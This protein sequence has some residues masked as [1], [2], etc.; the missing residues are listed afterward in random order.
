MTEEVLTKEEKEYLRDNQD[1][2]GKFV[3]AV[4]P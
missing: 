2:H 4:T 3:I 1:S